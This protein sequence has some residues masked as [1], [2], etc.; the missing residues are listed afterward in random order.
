M[1]TTTG[2]VLLGGGPRSIRSLSP[3]RVRSPLLTGSRL[4]YPPIASERFQ[5]ATCPWVPRSPYGPPTLGGSLLDHRRLTGGGGA[6][7][8]AA[9]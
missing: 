4:M 2:G 5:F 8:R 3:I 6:C 1:T 7:Q 9:G